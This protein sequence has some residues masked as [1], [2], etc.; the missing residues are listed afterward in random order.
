LVLGQGFRLVGV[1]TVVGLAGAFATARLLNG[2]MIGVN[3]ANPI[4]YVA[5]ALVLA[6]VAAAASYLPAR[7]ATRI[8]PMEALRPE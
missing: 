7:R 6:A 4:V 1:G 5:V 8:D 2:V 3:P